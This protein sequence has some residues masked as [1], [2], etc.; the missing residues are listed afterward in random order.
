[1][2]PKQ[3]SL[4]LTSWLQLPAAAPE[5]HPL[6]LTDTLVGRLVQ[7]AA[8]AVPH[9]PAGSAAAPHQP[10]WRPPAVATGGA[11]RGKEVKWF[12][13]ISRHTP[14]LYVQALLLFLWRSS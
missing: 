9:P 10:G 14:L 1:M 4:C 8:A 7:L 6:V 12:A 5:A 2:A 13:C 3:A 11:H